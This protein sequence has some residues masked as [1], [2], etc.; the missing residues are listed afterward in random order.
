MGEGSDGV[1]PFG[2]VLA[3]SR[4][5]DSLAF[6]VL[7]LFGWKLVASSWKLHRFYG[8]VPSRLA[9]SWLVFSSSEA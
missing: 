3:E 4:I 2:W 8:S 1:I 6:P 7:P 5:A 9:A